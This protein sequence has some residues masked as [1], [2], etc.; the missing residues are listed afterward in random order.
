MTQLCNPKYKLLTYSGKKPVFND[1]DTVSVNKKFAGKELRV[2]FKPQKTVKKK[3]VGMDE[4][5]EKLNAAITKERA[6]KMQAK[7]VQIMKARKKML[8]KDLI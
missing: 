8:F 2:S 6:A 5:E 4:G 1:D 3:A 7:I